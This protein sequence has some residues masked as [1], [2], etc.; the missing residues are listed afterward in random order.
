VSSVEVSRNAPVVAAGEVEV[1]APPE[2]V[3]DVLTAFERWP[4]WNPDVR[5]MSFSGDA[6]EGASFRW[7]AGPGT[8]TSTIRVVDRPRVIGWTGRTFGIDAV[9]VYRLEPRGS[10][11][12]VTT[13]ESYEGRLAR[14][15]R[16]PLRTMLKKALDSGLHRLKAEAE[17]CAAS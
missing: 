2:V 14:V 7:K 6:A 5:S 11:T 9:H 4:S 8:I 13:E 1:A 12:H 10:G 17:R 16:G 15:F 3:W